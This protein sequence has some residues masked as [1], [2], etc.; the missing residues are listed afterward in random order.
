M[1]TAPQYLT[2]HYTLRNAEGRVLDTSRGAE[3]LGCI[4]GAGQIIEGLEEPLLQ[5]TAGETLGLDRMLKVNLSR[6]GRTRSVGRARSGTAPSL[7][8]ARNAYF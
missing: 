6:S 4:E 3:P 1:P 5:M 7:R 2:F 8:C